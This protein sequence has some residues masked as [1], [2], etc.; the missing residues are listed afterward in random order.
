MSSE[1]G[2]R[3]L[4][5][6]ASL[7]FEMGLENFTSKKLAQAAGVTEATVYKYFANKHRLLQYYFQLYWTWLEQQIK[8]F[9][10]IESQ[11]A[12]RLQKAV[13]VLCQMPEVAADPGV[14]SKEELRRLVV[15]EGTKAYLHVQ[16]D[17]DNAK[18]L[19]APYKSVTAI[20]AAMIKEVRP[21]LS[22][23]FALATTLVEMSHSLE[24]YRLHLPALTDFPDDKQNDKLALFL[25]N[26][27]SETLHLNNKHHE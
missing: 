12:Q 23:P 16:V 25:L 20:L 2:R 7:I 26:I 3:M 27:L 8:V 5:V 18:K 15:A 17:A 11:V 13:R 4:A 14:V 9:T 6:G 1:S 22:Y 24:F 10:A 21:D 19:F